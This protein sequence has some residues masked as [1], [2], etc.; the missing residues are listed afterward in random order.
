M[1][2]KILFIDDDALMYDALLMY[3]NMQGYE[4]ASVTNGP[5]GLAALDEMKPDLVLLDVILPG[6]NG[7]DVGRQIR[8]RSNVPLI[9]VTA[10]NSEADILQGFHVGADDYIVKPFS[11]AVLNARIAAVLARCQRQSTAAADP[12]VESEDLSIN[13]ERKHVAVD[14]A[15]V[16]LTPTEYR[17]LETLARHANRTIPVS[18]LLSEVWGS[19]C[20]NDEKLVKQHIW[21]LRKKIEPNPDAPRHLI[22]RRGYGYRLE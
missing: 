14:G 10:R 3:L 21:S 4:V 6:M 16:E 19:Y 22:T 13:F 9:F 2:A 7:W 15:K 12:G 17:L 5:E 11:F 1:Q 20:E 8:R 18:Q